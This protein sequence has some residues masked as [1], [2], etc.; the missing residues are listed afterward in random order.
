M[1][2]GIRLKQLRKALKL[3]QVEFALRLKVSKGFL[4]NL[5]KGIRQ[6]SDQLL[7]LISYEFS[8]SENWLIS[9]EGEMFIPPIDAIENLMARFGEQAITN[10]FNKTGYLMESQEIYNITNHT[11]RD[12][13]RDPELKRMIDILSLIYNTGD[14]RT[15][16][17][18]SVQFD[19]AFPGD[20]VE[21]AEKK[22]QETARHS[23]AG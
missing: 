13:D 12:Y 4:S 16:S 10:A 15:K 18:I 20:I 23:S 17:W 5:E 22:Q 2:I 1:E 6:P 14:E 21:E 11:R 3:T 19:R 8:S 7:K 9:G